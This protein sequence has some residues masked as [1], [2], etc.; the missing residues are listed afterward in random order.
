MNRRARVL[1]QFLAVLPFLLLALLLPSCRS[2]QTDALT[3]VRQRGALRWGGDEE[4]G[5]P[6]I[7]RPDDNLK[8]LTGFEIDL[9][10]QLAGRLGVESD[11]RSSNW[12]ELL[13]TLNT[14][15]IDVVVNGY[16]LTP[17]RLQGYIATVPYFIYELHLFARRDD[18]RVKDWPDIRGPRPGG[19]KWRVGVLKNTEADAYLTRDLSDTVDVRRYEGTTDAFRDVESRTLDATLTDTPAAVYYGPRFQVKQIGQPTKRGYY[20][21]YLRPRDVALRDALND[22][23]RSAIQDGSLKRLYER[24]GLWNANQDELANAEVQQLPETLRPIGPGA[25]NWAIVAG[26]LSL[27]VQA[28]GITVMLSCLA[29]PLAIGIGLVIA[30][31]RVYGPA[32]LRGPLTAYVEIVR[33][34]PLLLQLYFIHFGI[35]PRL[36]LSDSLLEYAP[37]ISAVMGLALNYAAYEAEIYRAG[38][39]AIPVGQMEAALALGLSRWQA[40]WHVIVPQAVRLVIP[41]V[42]NDFINLFKDTSI[43]SVIAVSELTKRYNIASNNAPQAFV[44]LALVTAALYL[45]MSYPL[46]LLT[47]RLEKK[48]TTARA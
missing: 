1:Y 30:L 28:A 46:A 45:A 15:T 36:G 29:M 21:M 10:A 8:V 14:G 31:G 18:D 47:R 9:M 3:E 48:A 43:C 42:T 16:E 33:G 12:P 38:L 26:N 11:F 32:V 41:P 40:V 4:G 27:L 37:Y 39:L 24:Y 6:Y 44:E 19:G 13:N 35:V 2:G 34:T 7:F 25:G 23:L 5:G 22:G 17:A 20:V